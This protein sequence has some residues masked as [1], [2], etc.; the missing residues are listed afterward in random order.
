M[1]EKMYSFSGCEGW[2]SRMIYE[3]K[4]GMIYALRDSNVQVLSVLKRAVVTELS[5][6]HE[7]PVTVVC[8]YERNQF[9]LTACRYFKLVL[10]FML[11]NS[12]LSAQSWRDQVLVVKLQ[13]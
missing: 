1:I 3:P 2:V 13:Q 5:S 6:V 9:Y 7:A 12:F 4:F 11:V 10:Y 8:W